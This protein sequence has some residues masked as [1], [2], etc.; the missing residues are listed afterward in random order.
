MTKLKKIITVTV[1]VLIWFL[2]WEIGAVIVDNP[3]FF[4]GVG[5]TLKALS[6]L[7]ITFDFWRTVLMSMLR[8]LV[9]FCMGIFIGILLAF[10]CHKVKILS[11]FFAIGF[12]VIRS[13]PVASVIMILW[14]F[15]GSVR[16]ASAIALLMV[17][18]IIWQNLM[19]GY[20]TIDKQLS[21]VAD[22]FEVS[23]FKRFKLL[24]FPALIRYFVPA[25]LTSAGLAWKSGI[26]AEIITIAKN[27]IGYEIKTHKDFFES[28]YMLAWTL[29][30]IIISVIFENGIRFLVRR[31]KSY[32]LDN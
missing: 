12:S 7:I 24:V 1:S 17:A 14:I 32:E 9:G 18:P 13:T 23:G 8:I 6:H 21:E 26:A 2:I 25:L 20:A 3:A 31:F 19:D 15:I 16:V 5:P 28:D 29:V 10:I 27:S 11:N 30:V 4:A 22:I